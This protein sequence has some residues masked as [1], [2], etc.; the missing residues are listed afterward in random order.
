MKN[1][2]KTRYQQME[3]SRQK[4]FSELKN[5]SQDVINKKP[6]PDKWSVAE[7]LQHLI[8]SEEASL[9][10]IRKKTANASPSKKSGLSAKIKYALL[11]IAF[12]IP[13]KYKAPKIIVPQATGN[14]QLNE[15]DNKWRQI[16]SETIAI[17][18]KLSDNDFENELWLHPVTGKMSLMQMV[19]FLT[20]HFQ[21]HERQIKQTLKAISA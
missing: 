15:L 10:Y 1:E 17:I 5:Y 14:I 8:V 20:M 13:V 9:N 21:R 12:N 18:E 11:Q 2:F 19:D 16:R 7:V 3:A 4:L 6:A